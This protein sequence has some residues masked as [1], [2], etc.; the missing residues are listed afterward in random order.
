LSKLKRIIAIDNISRNQHIIVNVD[1]HIN[2]NGENGV[3]KTVTLRASLLFYGSRPGDIAKQKGDT[4]EGFSAFY[5]PRETSYLVYEYERGGETLCVVCTGKN[6]QVQ[7]QFL[8][9]GFDAQLFVIEDGDKKLITPNNQLRGKVEQKGLYL[10][11]KMGPDVYAEIIQ[12]NKPYRNKKGS[13]ELIRQLRPRYSLP[14]QGG[15]IHNVDRVLANIFSSKVSIG[16]I[17]SALT[18]I[19]INDNL[20]PSRVLRLDSQSNDINE[21]FDSR[22]AWLALELRRNDVSQLAESASKHTLLHDQLSAL[23]FHCKH[24]F[25]TQNVQIDDLTKAINLNR[26]KEVDAH[27]R[28]Y[29][30]KSKNVD[31]VVNFI[32]ELDSLKRKSGELTKIKDGF[33][34]G[35]DQAK[36]IEALKIMHSNLAAYEQKETNAENL[37]SQVSKG[38]E[39]ILAFYDAQHD[40]IKAI[41][42]KLESENQILIGKD[43]RLQHKELTE[44]S[45]LFKR[46]VKGSMDLRGTKN[47]ALQL[48]V[49]RQKERSGNIT[50]R[51]D[52]VGFS[53][54][55]RES[56]AT[57]ETEIKAADNEHIEA[58]TEKDV[59]TTDLLSVKDERSRLIEHNT[60]LRVSR[61]NYIDEQTIIKDRLSNGSLF[62]Y[63]QE[64]APEFASTIGKVIKPEIL[65]MKGLDPSFDESS[66]TIYG[67][68]INL[69][70]IDSTVELNK[71][72]LHA[73]IAA[74]DESI[75]QID[76]EI[77][78][79]D[80]EVGR[81]NGNVR[82]LEGRLSRLAIELR[83]VKG[84]LT[85][86]KKSLEEE[87]EKA[88]I[89]VKDR[90]EKLRVDLTV[91]NSDLG[92]INN[93]LREVASEY[94]NKIASFSEEENVIS[95]EIQKSHA[96]AVTSLDAALSQSL[97]EQDK[98]IAALESKKVSDIEKKGLSP[99]RLNEAEESLAIAKKEAKVARL[100]GE[101]VG[102][103]ELFMT[104]EWVGNQQLT[105]KMETLNQEMEAFNLAAAH[106]ESL[107]EIEHKQTVQLTEQNQE[108]MTK[109]ME[110]KVIASSLVS[111][112]TAMNIEPD[113]S[114]SDLFKALGSH[115]C[116]TKFI[117]VKA[118]YR[119]NE[120]IGKAY[121]KTIENTFTHSTGTPS[122]SFYERMRGE[123][124][125][126]NSESDLWWACTKELSE[127]MDSGHHSDAQILREN[128]CLVA[129]T[130]AD[131][132]TVIKSAHKSLNTLGKKLTSTT[133]NV[134]ERF[135]AIGRIS[136]HV[137]S[138]L[139]NLSYFSALEDFS[140]SH[141]Q[142]FTLHS[143][144]LPDDALINKLTNIINM[145]GSNRL[146]IDVDKSFQFEVRL[147]N[148][149]E[150]KTART[151]DEIE[152]LSS[153]GLSYLII[154][155]IY[156]GLINL[157]RTDAKI[158]L[159]FCVDE[160]GKLSKINTGKLI[161]LFSEHNITMISALPD[162]TADLLQYYPYA[163]EIIETGSHS[164]VY[165][166]YGD[167]S[168]VTPED[169]VRKLLKQSLAGE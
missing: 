113:P 129:K 94:E 155:A 119:S 22:D 15:S 61:K 63:L 126:S 85:E 12:S 66:N 123:L 166:L 28:L 56:I 13:Y 99:K 159:H 161:G 144:E 14:T 8:D 131:F 162:S 37:Y 35:S 118:D 57:L 154:T 112:L 1:G 84:Y 95:Q 78:L 136:I 38:V 132:S 100:A 42:A 48:K 168:R 90:H 134:V 81:L 30:L 58:I 68:S 52:D 163:Y 2:L 109:A 116:K 73:K 46:K 105:V 160:I 140:A 103:Y 143:H 122:R 70:G 60:N 107:L 36:P 77:E 75:V 149:G 9:T 96:N 146:E 104:T 7:Y 91:C 147:E 156:I 165:K 98:A 44:N 127:Y 67:L 43:L 50:A 142:W 150:T 114:K 141:E 19:L 54:Y 79:N 92:N 10:S 151:D 71:S 115:Q 3:G 125:K 55:F 97:N 16:H 88:K 124:I 86:Q 27:N 40:Q 64:N 80:A 23:L 89:E 133:A 24:L 41:K 25:D 135:E 6:G 26:A 11:R 59:I 31:V 5:F 157:L 17:Q 121:F 153:T 74:L 83:S 93:Q 148:K 137:S 82:S 20:I 139:T 169:K 29:N 128:Y 72:E 18:D 167:D 32:S 69:D 110:E 45:D 4:F 49:S 39:N 111:D 117:K 65:A 164:R 62:D 53:A 138:K 102:R 152:A 120:N 21:W 130:I 101:R 34:I 47:T 145:I 87:I 106:E 158:H 108:D 33:E 51:L 76:N